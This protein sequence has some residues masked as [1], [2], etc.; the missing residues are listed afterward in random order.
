M[1]RTGVL[2]IGMMG[3]GIY[4]TLDEGTSWK[5][6][7]LNDGLHPNAMVHALVADPRDPNIVFCG[8]DKG[9]Y[10]SV[11][12]GKTWE[13]S[14]TIVANH[15]IW[16]IAID[17]INPDIMFAGAGSPSLPT[18]FR[19]KDAGK[20]WEKRPMEAAETCAIGVP[21]VTAIA[22]DPADSQTIWAGIEVDGLRKSTDGGETFETITNQIPN[23]EY[24]PIDDIH[25]IAIT[26]GPP[27]TIF[28]LSGGGG[29]HAP[30]LWES[31]NNG[32]TWK[33]FNIRDNFPCI[34][35][36][37]GERNYPR[38][39]AVDPGDPHTIFISLGDTTPGHTG[40]IFRSKDTGNTWEPLDLPVS[41]NSALWT[42]NI[43]PGNSNKV[44]TGSRYG[45]VY[46]S[47][48]GGNTWAKL[49]R[50][51]SEIS[52]ILWLPNKRQETSLQN[53]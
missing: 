40:A 44:F 21:Q 51:C 28:V 11:D 43:P 42:V 10:R 34:G 30:D 17:P 20:T 38:G 1:T 33:A 47:D 8:C 41:P 32:K 23:D 45:Y 4:R 19:S 26:V 3:Q 52:S 16:C 39:I 49:W 9:I 37:N 46:Q 22:I 31:T 24:Y 48:D 25:N 15:H 6:L 12:Q 50:E 29:G 27:P 14:T 53:S 18:M 2:L 5:R 7:G 35:D 13:L 36:I